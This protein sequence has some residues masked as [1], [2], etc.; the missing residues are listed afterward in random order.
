MASA[1]WLSCNLNTLD[2]V[3][4]TRTM[5]EIAE[6]FGYKCEKIKEGCNE[7]LE[8]LNKKLPKFVKK[9]TPTQPKDLIADIMLYQLI[10]N[11]K[12]HL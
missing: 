4:V 12:K 2:D 10:M 9:I 7:C 5:E 11:K 3:D 6:L 1:F 8:I